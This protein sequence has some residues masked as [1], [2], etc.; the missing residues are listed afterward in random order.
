MYHGKFVSC[1]AACT[2]KHVEHA[3]I[4]RL[5]TYNTAI[6]LCANH[7]C[8]DAQQCQT[9]AVSRCPG[10]QMVHSNTSGCSLLAGPKQHSPA[11][12]ATADAHRAV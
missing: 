12:C 1:T 6:W 8:Y 3:P 9:S 7:A 11:Y 2:Y 10:V 4:E 5:L